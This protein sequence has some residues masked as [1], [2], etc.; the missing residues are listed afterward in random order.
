MRTIDEIR[1]ENYRRLVSKMSGGLSTPPIDAEVALA[2]GISKV[3]AWQLRNGKRNSI[4]SVAARKIERAQNLERGWM[5]NHW[6]FP[7]LDQSA[8]D[9]L[10]DWQ[11]LEIQG[12]LRE[13]IAS[14]S[15]QLGES[16]DN[17][18]GHRK[19]GMR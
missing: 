10:E 15:R 12:F 5:D 2:F 6:P 19:N 11:K 3:Y 18:A 1:M 16:Q 9:Q 7:N 4:D 13:K 17:A 8:F 14:Y